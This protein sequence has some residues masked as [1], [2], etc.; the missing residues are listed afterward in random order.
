MQIRSL[1]N[2]WTILVLAGPKSRDVLS[3]VSRGDWS[4]AAFPW[5]SVREAYVGIAP[6][7]V[8]AISFSGEL[9]YEIHI[10]N[11]QLY[12]AYL[13]L[14]EAGRAHHL[15]L[16][17]SRAIESMRMEKGHLHWKSDILTEFDPFETGLEHFVKMDKPN[18][19]GKAALEVRQAKGLKKTLVSLRVDCTD[20]AAHA[21]A[22]VVLG[23]R[24]VGTVTS[25]EWGHR[26]G[27]NL[28]YAFLDA[29]AVNA[30]GLKANLLG[31]PISVT[32]MPAGPYDPGNTLVRM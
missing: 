10:P 19:I 14:R 2:D 4:A 25:G 28:A 16:F 26:T 13:A 30:K 22:S 20:R 1:T 8:M 21:G 7:I 5:L 32:V 23:G 27:L 24:V 31:D 11:A 15:R 12:A 6:A 18:F 3:A 9:A 17:R 29:D